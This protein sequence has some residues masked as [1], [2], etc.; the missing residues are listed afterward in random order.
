MKTSPTVITAVDFDS[1]CMLISEIRGEIFL[2]SECL[3]CFPALISPQFR[4]CSVTFPS[5]KKA[6]SQS[7]FF[8][9]R[10]HN[11]FL[12]KL[13]PAVQVFMLSPL[14]RLLP[15]HFLFLQLLS[16]PVKFSLEPNKN[17]PVCESEFLAR[18]H[19][20]VESKI[21]QLLDSNAMS[22]ETA[23]G[24]SGDGKSE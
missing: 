20:K 13:V 5:D 2:M 9:H 19:E 6:I 22:R 18:I 21:Q 8:Q 11:S 23:A 17:L 10:G 7:S 4:I 24:S 3:T 14:F 16:S 15:L 12:N 1:V